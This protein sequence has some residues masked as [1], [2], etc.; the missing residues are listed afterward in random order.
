MAHRIALVILAVL[1]C[2][3][4]PQ[5]A[6]A[7][8][9][10]PNNCNDSTITYYFN[11]ADWSG[12]PTQRTWVR[13]A[14]ELWEQT[15]DYDG[16]R[17]MTMTSLAW[18]Q[19]GGSNDIEVTL[20]D[21]GPTH[22]GES[23]CTLLPYVAF[24]RDYFTNAQF[25]W[26][27][28]RHEMGHLA[29]LEHSG[30]KESWN[31]DNAATTMMTCV[32]YSTYSN[33]NAISQDDA[34]YATWAHS[35]LTD[36][37]LEANFGFEQGLSY[38]G[39]AGGTLEWQSSG[40]ATGPGHVRYKTNQASYYLYQTVNVATGDDDESYRAVV[41]YRQPVPGGYG[42]VTGTLFRKQLDYLGDNGCDY[43]DG[44]HDLN[45]WQYVSSAYVAMTSTGTL[46]PT[47]AYLWTYGASNWFNPMNAEGYTFQYRVY[48]HS[49]DLNFVPQW[50][51]FDNVRGEGT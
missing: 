10:H 8:P 47:T 45:D 39:V 2:L 29:G 11:T 31:G 40:G 30:A 49:Q 9:Q 17:L 44:L 20:A 35:D 5:A 27:T 14:I 18:G 50:V 24:N 33:T 22:Y 28:A 6:S 48:S 37:Q 4:V 25:L 13:D 23:S 1:A 46:D 32:D 34:A 41:N 16:T 38:W 15:L 43:A 12:Y 19:I 21:F 36:R 7:Y 42:S 51:Y 3:V 26:K